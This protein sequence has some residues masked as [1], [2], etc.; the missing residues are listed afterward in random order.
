VDE[1]Q[2]LEQILKA[3]EK[4]GSSG[5]GYGSSADTAKTQKSIE[6][7][8]K[9]IK[10]N[11]AELTKAQPLNKSIAQALTGQLQQIKDF[12][13]EYKKLDRDLEAYSKAI[14]SATT[15]EEQ[16]LAKGKYRALQEEKVALQS[17]QATQNVAAGLSNLTTSLGSVISGALI[18]GSIDF[19]KG[20]QDGQTGIE[21]YG[22]AAKNSAKGVTAGF[23]AVGDVATT[24]GDALSKL[25]GPIGMVG[26]A[27]SLLGPV[28]KMFST[29]VG[30]VSSEGLDMLQKEVQKTA[31]AF[32]STSSSGA[33][34]ADGMTGMR[35]A[36]GAAGLTVN[37]F[38]DVLKSHSADIAA[39]GLGVTEG[40]KKV[41]GALTA[42]G[43]QMQKQLRNL[44]FS[45]E[46]QAGLVAETMKSMKGSSTG[47]LA[48]TDQQVAEQTQKYAENLRVISAI[49]GEDAKAK[50]KQVQ[51][52]ANQLAFQQK[53]AKL[54]P[55]EQANVVDAMKN[56]S[57]IERKNFMDMV[58][59]GNVINK[60][61]AAAQAMSQGLTDSISES[62]ASFQAGTM[63]GSN[64]RKIAAAH[65]EA[66]KNDM[67]NN[68]SIA[69]AGA[70]GVG[71]LVQGLS[72]SMGKELQYRNVWTKDAIA[73]AE[74][75]AEAQ[76]NTIDPL[77]DTVNSIETEAQKIKVA[78]EK[79]LTP[80]IGTFSKELLAAGESVGDM[81]KSMGIKEKSTGE[82]VG[83]GVGMAAGGLGGAAAGAAAGAALGSVVP[84]LGTLVGGILG[85]VLGATGG[86]M[87]GGA[88]GGWLGDKAGNALG[89]NVEKRALGG[90]VDANVP[91]WVGE[92]GPELFKPKGA[93]S[94][95]PTASFDA[96]TTNSA[97]SSSSSTSTT[98]SSTMGSKDLSELLVEQ[99]QVLRQLL[100][101]SHSLADSMKETASGTNRLINVM[102]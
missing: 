26:V 77:T 88:A 29:V 92:N 62:Y 34:F 15:K 90:P 39:A 32:A 4:G 97:K 28:I 64:Q 89:G 75:A 70:A 44:G 87:G 73:A 91:Y 81:L 13:G 54:G 65:Q 36:A 95:I 53:L 72:E 24:A 49:T 51:E 35:N 14:K 27:L 21:L 42:G 20:L 9:L 10:A 12:S 50:S 1:K 22:N 2:L 80:A 37:Q 45:L 3:L 7:F 59:F 68:E 38:A 67:L 33:L 55:T 47:N 74:A 8:T 98:S 52:Q 6:E 58:N 57:E 23:T 79:E 16:D 96:A 102:S 85:G 60:E 82:K 30:K 18:N 40:A 66:I 100:D 46:E 71:G 19:A 86:A 17:A 78:F 76:K 31:K 56:M 61:G 93:G 5:S 63:S 94:I 101:N 25:P 84:V 48:A 69:L 83:T 43:P 41:G 11:T 99:T